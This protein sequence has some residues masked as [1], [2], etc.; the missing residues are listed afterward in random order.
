MRMF[1]R[2]KC[3]NPHPHL[4]QN[5]SVR[6]A[7]QYNEY[8]VIAHF[9]RKRVIGARSDLVPLRIPPRVLPAN[10]TGN[11]YLGDSKPSGTLHSRPVCRRVIP[12]FSEHANGTLW[13]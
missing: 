7:N 10:C 1:A 11:Q 9:R 2:K 12:R 13:C 5:G 4:F 6:E 8:S 3:I